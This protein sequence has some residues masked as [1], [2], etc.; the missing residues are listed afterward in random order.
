MARIAD[1]D[2]TAFAELVRR[3]SSRFYHVAYRYLGHMEDAEDA[4]Q[5]AFLKILERPHLWQNDK[6]AKF[7]TWFYRIVA[8]GCMDALKKHKSLPF[9]DDF[10]PEDETPSPEERAD[11]RKRAFALRKAL[12]DLPERQRFALSLCFGE[13]LS[14]AEAA[15]AM[16]LK[17]KALQALVMRGKTRLK[18]RLHHYGIL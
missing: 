12:G 8:N 7:T 17:L 11:D 15:E 2:R 1:G 13:G 5:A 4:V 18:E 14:N 10:D 16:G 6:G 3:H 9:S